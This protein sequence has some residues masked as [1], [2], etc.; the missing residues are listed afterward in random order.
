MAD[1]DSTPG[2][3]LPLSLAALGVVFGD[4]GTSPLYAIR[5]CFYGDHGLAATPANVLGIL[6]LVFWSLIIVVSIKYLLLV[7]RQSNDGEGGIIA[8]VALLRPMAANRKWVRRILI[9]LGI[10]GAALLYG[11]GT[12]TPAISVLSAIEGLTVVNA[13]LELWVLPLTVGIL[14]ALFVLQHKGTQQIGSIF[15][16]IM[17]LWFLA[18]A[19]LGVR[20][21]LLNPAVLGAVNPLHAIGFL[22]DNRLTGLLVLGTV[23]LVVTGAEALYADLGHFGL[24]PIRTAWF[25]LVLPSLVL[26]YFGQGALILENPVEAAHPFFHLAPAWST[27]ALIALA[28]AA[29]IIASQAVISGTFSLTA[30]A[31]RLD[32]LPRMNIVHT[33]ADERGQIYIPFVNWILMLATIGLVI[34]FD[35]ST[36]L[37]AAYGLAVSADMV[38]TT[39][40]A[41]VIA[42]RYSGRPILVMIIAAGLWLVDWSFLVANL[43]KFL[44]GGWYPVLVACLVFTIV[45]TWQRGRLLLRRRL[46]LVREPLSS[47]FASP[48]ATEAIR[49][50]GTAVFL[51]RP[52]HTIPPTLLHHLEHHQVLHEQVILLGIEQVDQPGVAARDRLV[53]ETL[54]A[55][56]TRLTVRYGY[57][58]GVNVPTALRLAE[59][60]GLNVDT[61]QVTYYI[62]R[63]TLIPTEDTA[64]MALWRER[65]FAFLSR[66]ALRTA[67]FYGIPAD[68]VVELGI[69]IEI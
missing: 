34:G 65:L 31:I 9:P 57:L 40:L 69:E 27:Y 19:V 36:R 5:Q 6:S 10:F 35:S 59:H 3:R 26:N 62:G 11:D 64:G 15:G 7:M 14:F 29:T 42:Y 25:A 67:V 50:P 24:G 33:S 46:D 61:S 16:P 47:F 58:Q 8:L 37:G 2:R 68:Q 48:R 4:I 44:A 43:F 56:F 23:F 30:Q 52:S 49:L 39:L 41:A 12:I 1:N 32:L 38:I 63:E 21:I 51:T 17:M 28:T 20:G 66:N 45:R 13:R 22:V 55:G 60:A 54:P 18:I 53:V